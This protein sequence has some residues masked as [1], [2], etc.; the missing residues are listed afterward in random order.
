MPAP[1][2][3]LALPDHA[4]ICRRTGLG[5][6]RAHAQTA[7]RVQKTVHGALNPLSR[8]LSSDRTAWG[9]WDLP[10]G[11]TVYAADRRDGAYIETL[12]TFHH[13]PQTSPK[14]AD[15][16][17]D[18]VDDHATL[19]DQVTLDWNQQFGAFAP[20]LMPQG[21]RDDRTLYELQLPADGWF[22]DVQQ[23]TTLA[24]LGRVMGRSLTLAEISGSD[25]TLT[26]TIATTVHSLQL[27]DGTSPIG[28]QYYSKWGVDHLCYALWLEDDETKGDPPTGHGVR[29]QRSHPISLI[30]PDLRLAA[31]VHNLKI[32]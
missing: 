21:W 1:S 30:D 27:D 7:W 23:T 13:T 25:R 31:S 10:G 18:E 19:L 22:V 26:T 8:D 2:S 24:A 9:R 20:G 11:R 5:L 16:F 12:Q 28:F 15:L 14:L 3:E 29:L 4:R 32:A 6:R 17:D